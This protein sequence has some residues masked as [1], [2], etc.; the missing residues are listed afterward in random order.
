VGGDR[1]RGF[2]Y[3]ESAEIPRTFCINSNI[4]LKENFFQFV[5]V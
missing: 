2:K 1:R 5:A 4:L 3:E